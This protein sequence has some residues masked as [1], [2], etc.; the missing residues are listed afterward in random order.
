MIEKE[1]NTV[2][3]T[4]SFLLALI[5]LIAFAN[6]IQRDGYSK[7]VDHLIKGAET[8]TISVEGFDELNSSQKK[9]IIQAGWTIESIE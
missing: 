4:L 2:I 7:A 9:N 8:R 1:N 6:V 5:S 3:I